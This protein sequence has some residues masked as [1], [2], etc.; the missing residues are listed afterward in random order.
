MAHIQAEVVRSDSLKTLNP[1]EEDKMKSTEPMTPLIALNR[2]NEMATGFLVSQTFFAACNLGLFD[3]LSKG[4]ATAEELAGKL[5]IHPEGCR[6]LLVA[7]TQIGLVEREDERYSNSELAGFL[8][9]Q[10]PV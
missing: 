9:S 3:Q 8:T 5:E 2:L 10:S 7:L 1:D 4:P 6:R